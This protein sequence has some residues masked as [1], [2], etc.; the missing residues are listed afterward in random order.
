MSIS[1][2]GNAPLNQQSRATVQA[3][4][5]FTALWSSMALLLGDRI[6]TELME[7]TG[8]NTLTILTAY[9]T[10]GAGSSTSLACES[11]RNG[12]N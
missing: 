9:W 5:V 10:R 1:C 12:T 3:L 11:R 2:K 7:D 4:Q 6:Y 8:G